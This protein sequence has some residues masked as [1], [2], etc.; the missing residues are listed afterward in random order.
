VLGASV[1]SVVGL[2]SR[3]FL[4]LVLI[5]FAVAAPIAWWGMNQWL[6]DFVYRVNIGWYLFA[7]T[8][9]LALLVALAAISF[10]AVRAALANP[11]ESLR[12][13]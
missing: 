11:V 4:L 1:G 7:I 12:S 10:Q 2:L 3:D 6:Q 5:A 8:G 9:V 13:E